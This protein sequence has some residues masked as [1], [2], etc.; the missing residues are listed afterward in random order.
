M[1]NI[2]KRILFYFENYQDRLC[3]SF[4]MYT[5]SLTKLKKFPINFKNWSSI[6]DNMGRRLRILFFFVTDTIVALQEGRGHSVETRTARSDE[7]SVS[8]ASRARIREVLFHVDG[9]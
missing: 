4:N 9:K 3:Q 8:E 6:A 2:F 1:L 7:L 5:V